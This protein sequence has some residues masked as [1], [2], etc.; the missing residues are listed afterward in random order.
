MTEVV[1][2]VGVSFTE[3]RERARVVLA[4]GGLVVAPSE[5]MYAVYASVEQPLGLQ[6]LREAR[7]LDIAAPLTVCMHDA[8]HLAT[9]AEV[10][11][12]AERL[13]ASY[14][15][16]PVTLVC[17]ATGERALPLGEGDGSLAARVPADPIALQLLHA[18][19]PLACSAGTLAGGR[20]PTTADAARA[21]LGDAVHLYIDDGERTGPASTVVDVTRGEAQVLRPGAVPAEHIRLVAAGGLGWGQLPRGEQHAGD[22][23]IDLTDPSDVTKPADRSLVTTGQ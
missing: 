17:T 12:A 8:R 3:A 10:P 19:G 11:D 13:V 16:G 14:W 4:S 1:S 5:T 15:P 18:C 2:V 21:A 22:T 23:V 6:R 7:G 9:M 20:P